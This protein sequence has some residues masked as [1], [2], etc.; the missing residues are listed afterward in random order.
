TGPPFPFL[1]RHLTRHVI[2]SSAFMGIL[3]NINT[4]WEGLAPKIFIRCCY[5]VFRLKENGL[6]I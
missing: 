6:G 4:R 3:G 5:W 1:A 2:F